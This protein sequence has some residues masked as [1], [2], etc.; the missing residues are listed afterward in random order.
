[1]EEK[2]EQLVDREPIVGTPFILVGS[3]DTPYFIALGQFKVSQEFNS[4]E[5]AIGYIQSMGIDW[6]F[7]MTVI[8]AVMYNIGKLDNE[9]NN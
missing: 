2:K 1:M 7:M 8:T 3:A 4:K 9:E 6:R 5:E